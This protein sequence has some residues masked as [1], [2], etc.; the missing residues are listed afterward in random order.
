MATGS[1]ARKEQIAAPKR[2]WTDPIVHSLRTNSL[3]VA[4]YVW[5]SQRLVPMLFAL[6][7]AAP[8]GVLILPFFIPKFLRNAHRRRKY[9]VHL[10]TDRLERIPGTRSHGSLAGD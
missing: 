4:M 2:I 10:P 3:L 5:I 8:I 7:A 9:G 1:R 6:L